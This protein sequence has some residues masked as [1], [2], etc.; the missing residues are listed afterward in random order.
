MALRALISLVVSSDAPVRCFYATPRKRSPTNHM[1]P[2]D[3]GAFIS[4]SAADIPL[5]PL[6]CIKTC[7]APRQAATKRDFA[8]GDLI[9]RVRRTNRL[10]D[11]GT[12][13]DRSTMACVREER[14]AP[15]STADRPSCGMPAL[16]VANSE[17]FAQAN[18]LATASGPTLVEYA[19]DHAARAP[20]HRPGSHPAAADRSPDGVRS[21]QVPHCRQ[22]G[23]PA[24]R[25]GHG[26][27]GCKPHQP[28]CCRADHR[29]RHRDR[30][31]RA[32]PPRFV[33]IICISPM[34]PFD[35]RDSWFLRALDVHHRAYPMFRHAEAPGRLGDECLERMERLAAR[36]MRG[37]DARAA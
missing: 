22:R 1:R 14:L 9:P 7:D 23:S 8:H 28:G 20:R 10:P 6:P 30:S 19:V 32:S 26:A 36:T 25:N 35:E 16:R 24:C 31:E 29:D 15:M 27:L 17:E 13:A 3:V 4:Q 37:G 33:G 11:C 12:S 18:D 34:A 21:V 2:T 5:P